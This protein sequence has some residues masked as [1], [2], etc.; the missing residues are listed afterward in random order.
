MNEFN[1]DRM[2]QKINNKHLNSIEG[3]LGTCKNYVSQ[4]KRNQSKN[5][6]K[7]HKNSSLL[8]S[9]ENSC[10]YENSS[11]LDSKLLPKNE[12]KND[13]L[14]NKYVDKGCSSKF[15]YDQMIDESQNRKVSFSK[16]HHIGE[17]NTM[18]NI[19]LVE[20]NSYIYK[21]KSKNSRAIDLQKLAKESSKDHFETIFGN[22]SCANY[23]YNPA[24][25]QRKEIAN[26]S[27]HFTTKNYSNTSSLSPMRSKICYEK[28]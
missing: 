25:V 22:G 26:K 3:P 11:I 18:K 19:S 14:I 7:F 23:L 6:N 13:Y 24:S 16:D 15:N 28:F 21:R 5:S 1:S 2:E 17:N 10:R 4:Q 8:K 12:V 27:Y 9:N 20:N